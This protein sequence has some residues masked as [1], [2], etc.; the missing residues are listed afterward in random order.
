MNA[1]SLMTA[2]LVFAATLPAIGQK[3]AASTSTLLSRLP[4]EA[5]SNN[6]Q[7]S[8]A[9]HDAQAAR[10]MV[11]QVTTLPDPKITYQQ[12]SVGALSLSRGT[13]TAISPISG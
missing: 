5:Q 2:T 8:A 7:L 9:D 3:T 4:A 6:S 11:R 12:F 13:R 1:V 10:Q